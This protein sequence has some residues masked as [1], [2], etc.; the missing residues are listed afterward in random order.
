MIGIHAL[1]LS[2]RGI[3]VAIGIGEAVPDQ[4][5]CCFHAVADFDAGGFSAQ[6]FCEEACDV[7][8]VF[9]EAV[10]LVLYVCWVAHKR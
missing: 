3:I 2:V 4:V 8:T 5:L 7:F 1:F 9:G 6:G 10:N